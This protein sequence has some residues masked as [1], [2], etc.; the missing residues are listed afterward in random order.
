L[1]Y[2]SYWIQEH[3]NSRAGQEIHPCAPKALP[4]DHRASR[5]PHG[6]YQT[7]SGHCQHITLQTINHTF[8]SVAIDERREA[9]AGGVADNHQTGIQGFGRIYNYVFGLAQ[10][11]MDFVAWYAEFS[12]Q[13]ISVGVR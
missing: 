5:S 6:I 9:R 10:L 3:H 4:T 11:D 2:C 7:N 13:C 8:H 1:H 12:D